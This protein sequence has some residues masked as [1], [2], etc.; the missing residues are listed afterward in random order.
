MNIKMTLEEFRKVT[1]KNPDGFQFDIIC[2]KCKSNDVAFEFDEEIVS[3]L[4]G[5]DVFTDTEHIILFKCKGCG[6]AFCK[7]NKKSE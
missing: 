4:S 1:P 3:Y 6:N 5:Y 2:K 7:T